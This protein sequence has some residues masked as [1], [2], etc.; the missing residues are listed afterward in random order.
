MVC[1]NVIYM[2]VSFEMLASVNG[3]KFNICFTL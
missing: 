2:L 3:K 1:V